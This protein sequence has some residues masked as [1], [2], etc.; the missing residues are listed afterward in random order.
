MNKNLQANNQP[1]RFH[2]NE[3][4]TEYYFDVPDV[5]NGGTSYVGKKQGKFTFDPTE[6]NNYIKKN[7]GHTIYNPQKVK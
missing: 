3:K 4:F 2:R 6:F 7:F 1:G 5:I